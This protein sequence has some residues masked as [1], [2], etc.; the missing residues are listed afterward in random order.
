MEIPKIEYRTRSGLIL[1]LSM[2]FFILTL[3]LV[4]YL[5]I[6]YELTF[7]I[8]FSFIIIAFVSTLCFGITFH[9]GLKLLNSEE[10]S[11]KLK[12]S[13]QR[14]ILLTEYWIKRIEYNQKAKDYNKKYKTPIFKEKGALEFQDF[15]RDVDDFFIDKLKKDNLKN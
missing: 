7:F 14:D 11:K 13:I 15:L 1:S 6:F 9:L 10:K 2:F 4:G 12:D 5:I 8:Q 3:F